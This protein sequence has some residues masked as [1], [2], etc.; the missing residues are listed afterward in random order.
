MLLILGLTAHCVWRYRRLRLVLTPE[1]KTLRLIEV[2]IGIVVSI[3]VVLGVW[4]SP[5]SKGISS[6]HQDGPGVDDHDD[7]SPCST[8]TSPLTGESL[9]VPRGPGY[10]IV[11]VGVGTILTTLT[12][13]RLYWLGLENRLDIRTIQLATMALRKNHRGD[14]TLGGLGKNLVTCLEIKGVMILE[15]TP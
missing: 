11:A 5:L 4:L 6:T 8:I 10:A 1:E 2:G 14:G 13:A 12:R 7:P 15:C 3:F 9:S